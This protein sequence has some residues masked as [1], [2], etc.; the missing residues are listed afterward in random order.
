MKFI[1]ASLILF[2]GMYALAEQDELEALLQQ[3]T[4][5]Y[6]DA[7]GQAIPSKCDGIAQPANADP[8]NELTNAVSSAPGDDELEVE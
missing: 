8:T 1:L 2:L 6:R 5:D 7:D 3:S 4:C